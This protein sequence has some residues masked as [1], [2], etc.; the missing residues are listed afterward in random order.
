MVDSRVAGVTYAGDNYDMIAKE[1]VC[2]A[3]FGVA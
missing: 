3:I 2:A 1:G